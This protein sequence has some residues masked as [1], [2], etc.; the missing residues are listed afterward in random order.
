MKKATGSGFPRPRWPAS[1]FLAAHSG[2]AR[3][4]DP[5]NNGYE[6][7]RQNIHVG[8]DG[9][10]ASDDT[11]PNGCHVFKLTYKLGKCKRHSA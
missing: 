3:Y 4:D 8:L 5:D 11:V 10:P 7:Y 1:F 6:Y 2:G 9:S